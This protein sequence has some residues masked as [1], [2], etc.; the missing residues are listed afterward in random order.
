MENVYTL[1][2]M[3]TTSFAASDLYRSSGVWNKQE[4]FSNFSGFQG[5]LSHDPEREK[6]KEN[7]IKGGMP[8]SATFN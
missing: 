1:N 3:P 2:G 8:P 6:K 5:Q 4:R 7:G